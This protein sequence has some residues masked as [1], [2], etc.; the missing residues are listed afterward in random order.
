MSIEDEELYKNI[1]GGYLKKYYPTMAKILKIWGKIPVIF[2][3]T[4]SQK[5][6]LLSWFNK[7]YIK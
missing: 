3:M 1:N 7:I 4:G 6:Q 5:V 2:W